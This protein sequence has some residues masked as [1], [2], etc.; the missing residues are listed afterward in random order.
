MR[1]QPTVRK[2]IGALVDNIRLHN[3]SAS[4]QLEEVDNIVIVKP[5][6]AVARGVPAAQAKDMVLGVVCQILTLLLGP[7]WRPQN[8]CFMRAAPGN[9]AAH[10][11]VF[12]SELD[13]NQDFNGIVCLKRDIDKSIAGADPG[14]AR[15]AERYVALL[16]SGAGRKASEE[17]RKIALTLLPTG[18]CTVERVA[19]HLG[20][21]RRTI[22][23]HLAEQRTTF[24]GIIDDLRA[25]LAASYIDRGD[26]PLSSV[27]ELLGFSAQSAFAHWHRQ[28]FGVSASERRASANR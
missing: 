27:A 4:L 17:I 3:E 23:R 13:F 25:E 28:R 26:R 21:D 14:L 2:A 19:K 20:I 5:D 8:V 22:H 12:G 1:E 9:L 7:N 10:R 18:H 15:E 16:R 11:R 24:S 6:L